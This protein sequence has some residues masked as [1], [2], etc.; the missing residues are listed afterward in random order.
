MQKI[1]FTQKPMEYE[2]ATLTILKEKTI[3]KS[4]LC[5]SRRL[6]ATETATIH[7]LFFSIANQLLEVQAFVDLNPVHR[8]F[9]CCLATNFGR[10]INS[11]A[12]IEALTV[13]YRR[14]P[15]SLLSKT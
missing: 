10:R 7:T 9:Y 6:W 4:L 2:R 15:D 3:V 14:I 5:Y 12:G 1:D 8:N 11:K 13:K